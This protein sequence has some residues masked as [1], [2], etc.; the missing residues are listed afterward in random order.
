M[1]KIWLRDRQE[2]RRWD[3]NPSL[4]WPLNHLLLLLLLLL[5]LMPVLLLLHHLLLLLFQ[6]DLLEDAARTWRRPS[7]VRPRSVARIFFFAED[8]LLAASHFFKPGKLISKLSNLSN[9]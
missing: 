4:T 5:M 2:V 8:A 9:M 6:V 3:S 7:R 1:I